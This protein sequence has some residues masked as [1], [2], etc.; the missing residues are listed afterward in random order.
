MVAGQKHVP[1]R[2]SKLTFLLQ[3]SLKDNCKV[4]MFV[5]VNPVPEY[6]Q[7]SS[8]SLQ[9]ATRCRSVQLGYTKRLAVG[10]TSTGGGGNVTTGETKDSSR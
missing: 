10:P 4:L 7:E 9:F 6:A 8:C 5:N 1:Y 2:N 3:D